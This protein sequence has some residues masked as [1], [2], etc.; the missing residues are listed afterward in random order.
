VVRVY[1]RSAALPADDPIRFRFA[2]DA[3]E[4]FYTWWP[5]V[6]RKTRGGDLHPALAAHLAKY[7]SLMPSLALLF[8]LSDTEDFSAPHEVSLPRAAQAAEWCDYLEAH[9]RRFYGCIV[10]PALRAA[11]VLA[12]K[13][14]AKKLP[15]DFTLRD[16]YRPQWSGLTTPEEGRAALRVLEDHAWVRP[17]LCADEGPGRPS[18]RWQ[19]NPGILEARV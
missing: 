18:E 13:I 9:A 3:Q 10:S 7:S 16:V 11:R 5:E 6:Q 1:E 2:D 19:T 15:A 14:A 8:E 4:L 12:E 17:A